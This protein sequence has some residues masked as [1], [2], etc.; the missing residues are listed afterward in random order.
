MNSE[1]SIL[2]NLSC[3]YIISVFLWYLLVE[4]PEV[5]QRGIIKDNIS[6]RY[7]SFK[8]S[9][10][11]NMLYASGSI[12]VDYELVGELLDH[13]KFREY[14]G[15]QNKQRWYDVLNGLDENERHIKDIHN[16][17]ELLYNDV[18]YVLNNIKFTQKIAFAIY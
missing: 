16:D 17:L 11:C 10:I 8:K 2:F 14:F 5:K 1:N 7:I 6:Q 9:T 12:G 3:G 18:T 15:G 13:M 4:I